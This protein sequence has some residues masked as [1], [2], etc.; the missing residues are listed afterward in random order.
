MCIRDRPAQT[1]AATAAA[2]IAAAIAMAAAMVHLDLENLFF[3]VMK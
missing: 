3:Y 1:E 2:A